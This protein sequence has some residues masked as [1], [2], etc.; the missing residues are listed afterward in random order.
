MGQ[1][2]E[3]NKLF[4]VWCFPELC[5]SPAVLTHTLLGDPSAIRASLTPLP[6][7]LSTSIS[8]SDFPTGFRSTS[9]PSA[10]ASLRRSAPAPALS[11][12][13]VTT[14]LS[15]QV[16][17]PETFTPFQS[18]SHRL[19]PSPLLT[20]SCRLILPPEQPAV[21]PLPPGPW[22]PAWPSP[23]LRLPRL[24]CAP[25]PVHQHSGGQREPSEFEHATAR[26]KT[27]FRGPLG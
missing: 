23:C 5:P 7:A 6:A 12:G 2:I 4:P 10:D 14:L 27:H 25:P 22:L 18:D 9:Q 13:P 26:F 1:P 19:H 11:S 17:R 8:R 20:V 3:P 24:P 16:L 15:T 21:F